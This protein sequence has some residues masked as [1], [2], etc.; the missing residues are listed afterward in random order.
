MSLDAK[1]SLDFQKVLII[2][3]WEKIDTIVLFLNML[4]EKY[5]HILT[6]QRPTITPHVLGHWITF[7]RFPLSWTICT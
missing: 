7:G 1:W 2:E 3:N 5:R 4:W 6:T